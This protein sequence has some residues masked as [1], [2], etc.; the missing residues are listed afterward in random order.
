MIVVKLMDGLGNQMFQYAFGRYLQTVYNE[1]IV[2]ETTKLQEGAVRR[3]GIQQFNIPLVDRNKLSE[4]TCAMPSKLENKFLMLFSKAVRVICEKFSGISMSG[5][6]AYHKMVKLGF[7]TTTDSIL[8]HDFKKTKAPVKFVRGY[9]QSEKYFAQI[10]DIIK[11]E[12]VVKREYS[13]EKLDFINE[14]NNC[15]SVCVH[16][17][18]GDYVGN[19]RF[20]VC[21]EEYYKKAIDYIK[22]NVENPVFYI[23]SNTKED[24]E[25]IKNNYSLPEDA[26]YVDIGDDEFDDLC[27]MYNC[28]HFIISNST[29][30]WW[31]SYLSKFE[32]ITI[33]PDRWMPDD[34]SED[35][36]LKEWIKI[37]F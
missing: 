25:W 9:F 37:S 31:G 6:K 16:I 21:T 33:S 28:H 12:F 26:R 4:D 15:E 2:F 17:R 19:K 13:G 1:P 27:F 18:R 7:Y 11:K 5:E 24:L 32:G 29:F 36:F 10:S 22:K 3:L 34:F 8:Y 20:E 35:I 14:L 23:F 30:S